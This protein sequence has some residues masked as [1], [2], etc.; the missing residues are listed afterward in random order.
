MLQAEYGTRAERVEKLRINLSTVYGLVLGKCN[1][2]LR[3]QLKGK[4]KWKTKSNERDLFEL[5]KI[6][7]PCCTN[8]TRTQ[9][10]TK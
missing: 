9:S 7:H 1:N 5:L 4:E 6:V 8:T 3:S 2:Y 10:N